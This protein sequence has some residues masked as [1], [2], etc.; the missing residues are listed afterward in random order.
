[1]GAIHTVSLS[2][3][4]E[5]ARR[6]RQLVRDGIDPIETR[7][8]KLS[9]RGEAAKAMTFRECADA[10][11]KSHESG[12]QNAKHAAQWTSTLET[13]ARPVVGDLPIN[14]VDTGLVMKILEPIWATK[15]ETASRVRG[16]IESILDWAMVRKCSKQ[17]VKTIR[18][19]G[20]GA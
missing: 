9:A 6:C 8:A 4:R 16:R 13:D 7:K 17:M 19:R 12:W 5:E 15:T 20:G 2:E 3:A 18:R 1:L 10:S 11:I 14:S